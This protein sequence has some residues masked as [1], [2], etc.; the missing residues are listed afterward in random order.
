M[1]LPPCLFK[2]LEGETSILY[3]PVSDYS[4]SVVLVKEDLG[5]Q[6]HVYYVSKILLDAETRYSNMK[7]LV[8]AVILAA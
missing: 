2:S 3:I 7:K 1:G 4:I 8:Y 6:S 5:T